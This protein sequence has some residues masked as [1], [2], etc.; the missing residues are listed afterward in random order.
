MAR[1]GHIGHH[2]RR[3]QLSYECSSKLR[4]NSVDIVGNC[5]MMFVGQPKETDAD[6]TYGMSMEEHFVDHTQ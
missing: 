6:D 3:G 1:S 5:R 4:R 2:K